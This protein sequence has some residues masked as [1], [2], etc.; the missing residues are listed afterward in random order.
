M[1]RRSRFSLYQRN[2]YIRYLVDDSVPRSG[3]TVPTYMYSTYNTNTQTVGWQTH[4][5]GCTAW[6]LLSLLQMFPRGASLALVKELGSRLL[7]T[8]GGPPKNP[9][10]RTTTDHQ[11]QQPSSPVADAGLGHPYAAFCCL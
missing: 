3:T 8:C 7:N 2:M 11:P 5:N 4:F 1:G 9:R 6:K 10:T